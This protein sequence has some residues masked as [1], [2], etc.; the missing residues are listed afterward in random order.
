[1]KHLHYTTGQVIFHEG[2]IQN[3]LFSIYSGKVGIY[4][5]YGA[6]DQVLLTE[7]GQNDCFGEMGMVDGMPRSAT[8]VAL[9]QNTQLEVVTWETL[10]VY[11]RE[12]PARVVGIMQMMSRRIRQLTD[13]YM[14]ACKAITEA[15]ERQKKQDVNAAWI[16]NTMKRYLDS[17]SAY[18][19]STLA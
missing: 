14:D 17:Y 11:C 6:E 19:H 8:A 9:Q 10:G 4:K 18:Q 16:Q 5:N 13:D 2:E 15:V 7:L 12:R 3:Y 1:M